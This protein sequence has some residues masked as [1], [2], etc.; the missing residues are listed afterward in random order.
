MAGRIRHED[1]QAVREKADIVKVVSGYL[2]LKK[3]GRDSMVGICPF[4]SPRLWRGW[5]ERPE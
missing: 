2:Q 1:I 5:P 3:A 4:R